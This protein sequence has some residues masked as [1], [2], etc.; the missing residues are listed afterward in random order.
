MSFTF[1]GAT[2]S[3][4]ALTIA[5]DD[6][7]IQFWQPVGAAY[8]NATT[9]SVNRFGEFMLGASIEGEPPLPMVAPDS[10]ADS[11]AASYAAWQKLPRSFAQ[12]WDREL[13]AAENAAPKK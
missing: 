4:R 3:A 9:R 6:A 12:R 2:I 8:P 5:D 11:I 13:D 7:I 10:P 1:N